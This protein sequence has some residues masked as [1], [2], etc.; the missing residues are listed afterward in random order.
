V[1]LR[2]S[3]TGR[4]SISNDAV[5]IDEERFP[6]RQGRLVF[7][8]LVSEH[9]R[10]VLR[11]QLADALWGESPPATWEKALGGIA[12]KLR[13]LLGECGI[14]GG[15]A[16][17]S[18]FGC[19][20]LELPDGTWID[21]LAAGDGADRAEAA[22]A[23]GE[24]DEAKAGA[25]DAAAIARRPLLP[26]E[27]GEWVEGKRREL[28][29]VRVRALDCLA[30]ACLLTDHAAEAA[31]WADEAIALEPFRESGYR[32]LMRAHAAAGNRAEALRAYERCRKLLAEEL[33]AY[34]SPETESIYRELLGTAPIE[35]PSPAIPKSIGD[36]AE[37]AADRPAGRRL[38]PSTRV[39]ALA[40]LAAAAAVG[41]ALAV[42]IEEEGSSPSARVSANAV[43]VI[44][45]GGGE[46][47]DQ[48]RLA[49]A[50]TGVAAST[51]AIWV[52]SPDANVVSRIDPRT[53][54]LRQT[55]R[56]GD[57]P[58]GI[59]VTSHG[60]WVA[61][62]LDGTV[63]RIDPQTNQ[64]VQ[65]IVVGNGPSGVAS[66]ENAVWVTNSADGT[67]SRID[68]DTGRVTKTL[69]A[70]IGASGI[71]V[72]Y[73]RVWIVSPP[74]GNVVVLDPRSGRILQRIAVGVDPDAVAAGAGAVWVANRADGTVSKF[75]TQVG[76]VTDTMRVGRGPSGVAAGS[77]DVWVANGADG[78]VS[79]IDPTSGATVGEVRLGNPTHGIALSP[80]GVYVAVRSTG[81]EHRGG[82]LRV[83]PAYGVNSIDPAVADPS[84]FSV[85]TLTNDG[86]VGFRRAS[87]VRGAQLVPDLA[88]ALPTP[89]DGGKTYSFQVRP[90]IRYA[91]GKLV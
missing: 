79:H 16:L 85:L 25:G 12:S 39:I 77:Q 91:N 62:G 31:K 30:E 51:N 72:A 66:G 4:V 58:E 49:D 65:T 3:L 67:V 43:G 88:A 80:N 90:G 14:D 69:P 83:L 10:P 20:R 55:I 13:S 21:V 33:G 18:A 19:Y 76:A 75:D 32:R 42:L 84:A 6:G 73:G 5:L 17:T 38:R 59:A 9:G 89:T 50:P 26:G 24:T 52:T 87:G 60:V 68:P 29:D 74:A 86:L 57:G 37:A 46:V 61:N 63:S 11:E 70:A 28:A 22:L 7:A 35:L 8:Y 41:I 64:V 15:K 53:N 2:V 1:S 47:S 56:V 44:D 78:T 54:E 45:P 81:I 34:P 40:T 48:T 82:T 71:V 36:P 23:A 27:H